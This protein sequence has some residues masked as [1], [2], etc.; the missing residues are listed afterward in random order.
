MQ[1]TV[2]ARRQGDEKP[3]SSVA[4]ETMKLFTN[5]SYGYQ[6][7]YR[8]RYSVTEYINGEKTLA[9]INKNFFKRLGHISDQ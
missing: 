2:N 8:S 3:N 6:F 7:I 9:A 5:R 4:A 1:S